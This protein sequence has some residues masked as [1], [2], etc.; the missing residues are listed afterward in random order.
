VNDLL[1]AT[2]LEQAA[3]LRS[4][5][6]SSVEL[7]Q[8]YLD[9]IAQFNGRL[10]AF[11]QVFRRRALLDARY[12]DLRLKTG[13][14]LP[15][16]WGV[17]IGI[18]DL[19]LVRG[20]RT[21]FGSQGAPPI[22]SPVDDLVVRRLRRAGFVILGKLATSELG[23]MPVTEPLIHSP[24]RNPWNEAHTPG[25]SSGGSGAAVAA[26]LLPLA[27]GTDGA[28]SVRIP[29]AFC[30]LVGLKPSRGRVPNAFGLPD[31]QVLYT[32]GALTRSVA[33]AAA[34]LDVLA[35][36]DGGRPHWAPPPPRPFRQLVDEKPRKLRVRVYTETPLGPTHPEIREAVKRAAQQIE[37]LG[38]HV[39]GSLPPRATL[40]EFLPL[41]QKGVSAMPFMRWSLA[42]PVTRWLAEPGRRLRREEVEAL[43]RRLEARMLADLGD[44]TD[45]TLTPTVAVPPPRVGAFA[46]LPPADA[47]RAAALIGAFTAGFNVTGQP[48]A[49]VPLGLT[50]DGLPMGLQIGARR[51]AD[52]DVLQLSRQLEEAMPWRARTAP[53][54]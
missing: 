5:A 15:R 23:A 18:K 52:A 7:V 51:F 40:E 4:R 41:W 34:V 22:W 6:I 11:V 20:S 35:G 13:R 42:Q 25:G 48:A 31:R 14:P 27:H 54:V 30:H 47:F 44:A 26:G 24:T 36:T 10:N 33:D 39:E 46:G 38:H 43:H 49:S 8:L 9:R 12:K 16:F 17:P 21:R 32:A 29:A 2:A 45:I 37:S 28:G 53:L 3:L 50:S 1:S 19:S